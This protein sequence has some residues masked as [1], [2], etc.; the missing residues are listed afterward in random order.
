MKILK[1]LRTTIDSNVDYHKK[2][3][4]TMRRSQGKLKN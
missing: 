2:E 4:E 1:E 3:L